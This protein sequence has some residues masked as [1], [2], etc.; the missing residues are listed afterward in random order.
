MFERSCAGV[1]GMPQV[2][3]SESGLPS[4][5]LTVIATDPAGADQ[6]RAAPIYP[7]RF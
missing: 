3:L 5:V 7:Y 2:E 1:Q 4:I 6:P